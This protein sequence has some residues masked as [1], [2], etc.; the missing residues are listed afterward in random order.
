LQQ[1]N[2]LLR[3]ITSFN[4][5]W[6]FIPENVGLETMD[7]AFQ[8]VTLPHTNITLPHRNFDNH[9]YAFVS[10][11]RK[12]FTLPEA[13]SGRRVYLDFDGALMACEVFLNGYRIGEN[14]GGFTPFSFD[15]TDHLHDRENVLQVRLDSSER[16]DIPPYGFVVDYLT[17]GGLYRDVWLRMVKPC[18]IEKVFVRS[19]N[20]LSDSASLEVDVYFNNQSDRPATFI[21]LVKLS[22]SDVN[23]FAGESGDIMVNV[24]GNTTLKRT[25]HFDKLTNIHLWTLENPVLYQVEIAM[26]S[27]FNATADDTYT[28]S[29]GFR[30]AVFKDDGFYLNG[31]KIKLRGVN[32]HQMYPYIGAAAPARLQRKD[33]DII[34]YELGCNIARTSHY[35]QSPHFLNRCDEIGLLVFEEIPGWQ[36]IGDEDWQGITLRDVQL[37]IERDR[38]H[39]SIVIWG[40]RINESLDNEA[41]YSATNELAHKLDPTR[42]T[43]GVRYFQ[44]SQFLEDVFTYNDFSNTIVEPK[45]TPHLV[46]EFMGHMFPT[47][48]WDHEQRQV[49]HALRHAHVQDKAAGMDNVTGAIAWCA[50]DYNTHVEFGSGDRVCYHGVMDMFRLPKFAAW[51]YESQIDPKERIILRPATFYAFGDRSNGGGDEHYDF[52]VFSNCDEIEVQ[53]GGQVFGRYLPDRETYPN[54]AHPPFKVGDGQMWYTYKLRVPDARIIGYIGGQAVIEERLCANKLPHAL[55]LEADDA[56]LQ[57]D[58]SDM[59]RLVFKIVDEFGHRLPHAH[60]IVS[61]EIEGPGELIGENPFVLVG[62]QA[63]MY[64]KAGKQAGTVKVKAR[65]ARL[66]S[67]TVS[68]EIQ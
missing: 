66:E 6:L 58:G 57:A 22:N 53:I 65:T 14:E 36:F 24:P 56:E 48:T 68:I 26:I 47:K 25:F 44:D 23:Y 61:F 37:M 17:F 35:P 4:D 64:V 41:F 18:Y 38:N 46:T 40:V 10:T 33:A 29:F 9:E 7:S 20:V 28:T 1:G 12:R 5:Q 15:I 63:A 19:K 13:K 62:G 21:P 2:C 27:N 54:L 59:T 43:G 45:N 32:R 39:P 11:Y 16:P 55:T 52:Y 51:F 42:Q 60:A 34:K 8:P 67:A 49:E 50:F 3:T 30:D 31:Q